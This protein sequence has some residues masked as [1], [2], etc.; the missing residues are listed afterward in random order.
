MALLMNFISHSFSRIE[1][2]ARGSV[3]IHA[4]LYCKNAPIYDENDSD[5][6]IKVIQFIDNLITCEYDPKNPYMT[7]QRHKHKPTC[8]KGRKNKKICRFNYPSYVMQQTM[9]LKPLNENELTG[10]ETSH[11]IRIKEL[12]NVFITTNID[13]TFEDMLKKLSMSE[14]E[15]INAIR[16]TLKR[17]IIFLKRS[18]IEFAINPYNPTI[19]IL[20]E[21]NMDLQKVL[22]AYAAAFY[23]VKYN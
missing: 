1:F 11:I 7:F 5:S 8:Y 15:Y 17:N 14:L 19:L 9:I 13:I 6:E 4:L 23:M 3:H 20:L 16:C 22:D 18:S 21:S 10:T 2:Q 12:M